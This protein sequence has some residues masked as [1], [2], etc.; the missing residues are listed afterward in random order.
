MK[1][2]LD[3]DEVVVVVVVSSKEDKSNVGHKCLISM[4]TLQDPYSWACVCKLPSLS[5]TITCAMPKRQAN[6]C[7]ALT[8]SC[9]S[10]AAAEAAAPVS[11]YSPF[12]RRL[13]I[14]A[15][16]DPPAFRLVFAKL[17]LHR[18]STTTTTTMRRMWTWLALKGT[19]RGE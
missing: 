11:S 16:E 13:L 6:I 9:A 17:S 8:S 10:M 18:H 5:S 14:Y 15:D 4:L 7:Q 1:A 12:F 19:T 3:I 2:L